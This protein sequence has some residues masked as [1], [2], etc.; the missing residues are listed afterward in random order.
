MRNP[1]RRPILAVLAAL[2]LSLTALA[3][4]SA[5]ARE[6]IVIGMTQTCLFVVLVGYY[7][8]RANG[9]FDRLTESIVEQATRRAA[10]P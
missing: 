3:P 7:I 10:R 5:A 4:S 2:V 8:Y 9:E 1:F 6:Q